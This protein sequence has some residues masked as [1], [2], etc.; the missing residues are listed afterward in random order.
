[1]EK[2]IEEVQKYPCLYGMSSEWYRDIGRKDSCW[3]DTAQT[4]QMDGKYIKHEWKKLQD[5]F[6]QALG[7]RKTS[8]GQAAKKIKPWRYEHQMEFLIPFMNQRE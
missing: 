3:E 5:C 7:R 2:L 8:S 4:L 6:R 1:M